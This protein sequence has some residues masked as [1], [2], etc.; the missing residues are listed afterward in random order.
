M[1][2]RVPAPTMSVVAW[3]LPSITDAAMAFRV[4][5]GASPSTEKPSSLGSWLISTV[6]AMP[7]M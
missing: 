1:T 2:A 3:V 6:N 4:A 7:F 5:S